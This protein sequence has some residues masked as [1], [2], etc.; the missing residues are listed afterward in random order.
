MN[1]TSTLRLILLP[2]AAVLAAACASGPRRAGS[3]SGGPRPA[4]VEGDS[5]RWPR[6]SFVTGVGSADD[7]ASAEDRARAEVA[8]VFTADVS[9]QTTVAESET[10]TDRG[11]SFSQNVAENVRTTTKKV[12]EGVDI[13]AR[14]KDPTGRYYAL[15]ALPK[16]QALLAVTEKTQTLDDEAA[17]WKKEL[18]A[19][20]DKFSR[21]KA[22][23]KL[24]ALVKSR[25]DLDAERR[26]LGG[27]ASPDGAVDAGAV[28]AEAAKALSAL[29][30]VVAVSGEGAEAVTTGVIAGLN[31]AGLSAKRGSASD[32]ADLR[33]IA[34][35]TAETAD[36]G[37]PRWKRERASASVTLEDARAGRAFAR[38]DV[39]A[40]E[41]S[42]SASAARHRAL[43]ALSKDV[44]A[45]VSAAITAFF[46]D[47]N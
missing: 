27:G 32:P 43:T 16:G 15:A 41:D 34:T 46:A 10:N 40:R 4:W 42:V 44:A 29:D 23:A 31:A 11:H 30:V 33:A 6:A 3:S 24:V 35:V 1:R 25:E 36:S 21:A 9:V 22:A 38:F 19:A 14:W 20:A 47:Q 2:A 7:Q 26:V 17:Q 12:L 37:D 8:R 18:D 45:K 5:A 39:S 13:V 28:R